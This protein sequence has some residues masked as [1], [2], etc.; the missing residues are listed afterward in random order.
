MIIDSAATL[1]PEVAKELTGLL[2]KFL[3]PGVHEIGEIFGDR[4]RFF[5]F[6]QQVKLLRRAS[7][8]LEDAKIRPEVVNSR[9][10]LPLMQAAEL[11]DQEE[12][13]ER[14]AS[15]LASAADPNNNACL[16]ASFIEILKQLAPTHAFLLDIFYEQIEPREITASN[17]SE[18][19]VGRS[20]L[21]EFLENKIPQFDVALENLLRLQL[22]Q[23]PTVKLGVANGTDLRCVVVSAGIL[24]ATQ[25]GLAFTSA[26]GRGRTPRAKSYGIPGD[27]VS[28]V[29]WT[30]GG[31]VRLWTKT[32]E[33][34]WEATTRKALAAPPD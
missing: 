21:K 6:Q 5:R 24:C 25:L 19:G 30:E 12:M 23:H 7:A 4:L 32:E 13:S 2:G 15:L 10:L 17:L 31:S 18:Q 28:N 33:E 8:I 27:S 9:V 29:F 14:W 20:S 16:E 26:C 3:G 22:I 34:A 11:E 1:S